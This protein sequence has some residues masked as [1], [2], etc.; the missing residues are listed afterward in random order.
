MAGSRF[1]GEESVRAKQKQ[2]DERFEARGS[3]RGE[4]CP[5]LEAAPESLAMFCQPP[6]R[7]VWPADRVR[8]E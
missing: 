4:I 1:K 8:R 2:L 6:L 5:Q 3:D 7:A